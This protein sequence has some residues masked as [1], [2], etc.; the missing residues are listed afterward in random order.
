MSVS[1]HSGIDRLDDDLAA[2]RRRAY[3]ALVVEGDEAIV[4]L[5]RRVLEREEFSVECVR[6]GAAAIEVMELVPCDLLILDLVLPVVSG[7]EVMSF[8]EETQPKTLR[9][10]IVMTASPRKL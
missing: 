7:E 1:A 5:V 3:R 6:T 10:V 2:D 9:R 8:I 4:T